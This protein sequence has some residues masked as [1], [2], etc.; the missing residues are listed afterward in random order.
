MEHV[1]LAELLLLVDVCCAQNR[2][3]KC[4]AQIRVFSTQKKCSSNVANSQSRGPVR[5]REK[6]WARLAGKGAQHGGGGAEGDGAAASG[7]HNVLDG[8]VGVGS[9]WRVGVGLCCRV[10]AGGLQEGP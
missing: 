6:G 4:D 9:C 5:N 10:G 8:A 7:P 1:A 2:T 3:C